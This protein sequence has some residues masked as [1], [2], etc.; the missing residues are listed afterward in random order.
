MGA[1]GCLP[2]DV[3]SSSSRLGVRKP[4][5]AFFAKVVEVM[6]FAA[7]EVAYVGDR[8]VNDVLP[9]LAAGL[10]A[11]HVRRGPWGRLQRTPGGALGNDS[12][13]ELPEALAS[14]T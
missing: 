10:V 3:I 11:G 12:L 4:E 6:R 7:T 14:L 1:R 2:A 8:V 13:A 9:A 5:P